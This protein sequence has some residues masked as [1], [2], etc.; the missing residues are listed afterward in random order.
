MGSWLPLGARDTSASSDA[1]ARLV[2]AC[3]VA[4]ATAGTAPRALPEPPTMNTAPA[5]TQASQMSPARLAAEAAFSAQ[6]MP[7]AQREESPVVVV[8]R[9]R[10]TES[11]SVA[12]ESKE[13]A[14]AIE[15][16]ARAPRTY[17]LEST[18]HQA[19]AAADERDASG[20]LLET[21]SDG[22][23]P[24][25]PQQLVQRKRRPRRHGAVR[26]IRPNSMESAEPAEVAASARAMPLRR[27]AD[28]VQ[29]LLNGFE[30]DVSAIRRRA[31]SE[32]ARVMAS[33][34]RL[35]QRAAGLRKKEAASALRWIKRAI[36]DYGLSRADLGL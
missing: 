23:G 9:P 28:E 4:P 18:A 6:P 11:T 26:I 10:A 24:G 21:P 34:D 27:T 19:E 3:V 22:V 20:T 35:E 17:R 1:A 12:G 15:D 7:E 36:A 32:H 31:E 14:G 25:S 29:P 5:T 33:I 8:K 13:A 16:E 2:S 30:F